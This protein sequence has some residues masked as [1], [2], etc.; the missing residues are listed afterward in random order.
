MHPWQHC[1]VAVPPRNLNHG[2]HIRVNANDLGVVATLGSVS[3]SCVDVILGKGNDPSVDGNQ[4]GWTSPRLDF[5]HYHPSFLSCLDPFFGGNPLPPTPNPS[6]V[7]ATAPALGLS[8]HVVRAPRH[9]TLFSE[10]SLTSPQG[11]ILILYAHAPYPYAF[12]VF[13]PAM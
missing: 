5:P 12:S 11:Q 13:F 10:S 9:P 4:T 6:P 3:G 1:R 2:W 7:C 8:H